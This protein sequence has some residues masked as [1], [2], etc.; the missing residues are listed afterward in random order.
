M[1]RSFRVFR[2]MVLAWLFTAV[3]AS[4]SP[5][6]WLLQGAVISSSLPGASVGDPAS[7]SLTFESSGVDM[8]PDPGCGIYLDTVLAA[9][10]TFGSQT[11]VWTGGGSGIEI[12]TGAGTAPGGRCGLMPASLRG[13]TFRLFGGAT[14]MYG[15]LIVFFEGGPVFSD[16]LPLRPP[17]PHLFNNSGFR[18]IPP[19]GGAIASINI[20]QAVPEPATLIFV[21]TGVICAF[22]RRRQR[23]R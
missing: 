12:S 4:A 22:A 11:Y 15:F 13:V 17:T 14:S 18:V 10:A 20:T 8:S 23:R 9:S 21:G 1:T 3:P 19:A 5:I 7:M 2:F 16:A 6:C